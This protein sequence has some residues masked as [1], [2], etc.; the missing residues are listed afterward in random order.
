MDKQRWD[1]S[2]R[3]SQ[4]VRRS[5]KRKNEKKEEEEAGAPNGK[6]VA[7]H[8]VFPIICGSG[9]SKSRLAKAAAAEPCRQMRNEKSHALVARSTL[10]SQK[11]KNTSRSDHFLKLNCRK[12]AHR[13]GAKHMSNSKC[14]KHTILGPLS[15]V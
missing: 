7:I 15:K 3:R 12:S 8:C 14:I 6:K 5:E 10:P 9:R 1:E 2:E 11:A 13:C 4:E